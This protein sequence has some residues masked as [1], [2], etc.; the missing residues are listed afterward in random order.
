MLG[1]LV[2]EPIT[3]PINVVK[4]LPENNRKKLRIVRLFIDLPDRELIE[5]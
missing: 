1:H 5:N 4:F 2:T 3:V